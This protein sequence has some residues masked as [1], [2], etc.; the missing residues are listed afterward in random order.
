MYIVINELEKDVLREIINIS[1][2]RAA[3]SFAEFSHKAILL[4]V[5]EIRIIEPNVLPDI[6]DEF[7]EE[8]QIIRSE[9]EGELSGKTFLLFSETLIDKLAEVCLH[10]DIALKFKSNQPK[11]ALLLTISQIITQA[12]VDELHHLLQVKLRVLTSEALFDNERLPISYILRDLP[13]HQP[14]IIAIKTQFKRVINLVELPFI[15]VLHANS[16][17]KLLHI[18]RQDNLYNFK[19]LQDNE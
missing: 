13:A 12:L 18:L 15:I 14:F 6:I 5:P 10:S 8:Y 7:E 1:L 2:A 16:V 4:A 17:S 19:L 11:E 9:I 3:D